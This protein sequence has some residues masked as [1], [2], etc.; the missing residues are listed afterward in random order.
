MVGG[1]IGTYAGLESAFIAQAVLGV[2]ASAMMFVVVEQS[3]GSERLETHGLGG[4]IASTLVSNRGI[5][6]T[7]GV[8]MMSLG[9]LRQA[10]QVLFPYGAITL[11]SAWR[12]DRPGD[13]HF[14]SIDAA[15]V[16]SGRRDH[17]PLR[18]QVGSGA[19]SLHARIR[20]VAL[21][22][23]DTLAT[24]LIIAFITGLGNGFGAGIN[25]TLGA[26][27]APD[28]GR[29]EFLGVSGLITDVGQAGGPAVISA[30]VGVA[31]LAAASVV[32]GGIGFVGAAILLA[33][34]PE[35]L[36]KNDGVIPVVPKP[37]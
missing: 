6:M 10:R 27:F 29:G 9:L 2:A 20:L 26:D 35:T 8:P 15:V 4:R 19:F 30:I 31:S 25:Q 7:A 12:P 3:S 32:S 21:P 23:T 36:K 37:G 34:M 18:T 24:F 33:Y 14:V 17:R 13:Q 5:F 16:L 28:V 1:V 11:A 22:L